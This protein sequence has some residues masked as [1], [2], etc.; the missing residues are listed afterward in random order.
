[1]IGPDSRIYICSGG[2]S[3]CL[4]VFSPAGQQIYHQEFSSPSEMMERPVVTI[5]QN[6]DI[7]VRY[8]QMLWIGPSQAATPD[9]ATPCSSKVN[10]SNQGGDE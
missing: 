9:I 6:G 4:T 1:L 10:P 7:Y 8:C 5:S 3:P 2:T